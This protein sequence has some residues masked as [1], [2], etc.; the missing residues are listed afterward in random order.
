MEMNELAASK[1]ITEKKIHLLPASCASTVEGSDTY[2]I[3]FR[4]LKMVSAQSRFRQRY[5]KNNLKFRLLFFCHMTKPI[6]LE[7]L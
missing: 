6:S 1:I 2:R 4:Y 5:I 7:S 3:P